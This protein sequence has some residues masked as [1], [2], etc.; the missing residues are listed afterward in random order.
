MMWVKNILLIKERRERAVGC[1]V[2][3]EPRN[4]HSSETDIIDKAGTCAIYFRLIKATS[5]YQRRDLR[6]RNNFI[7]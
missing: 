7:I 4:K 6:C 3:A 5:H 2:A 1:R